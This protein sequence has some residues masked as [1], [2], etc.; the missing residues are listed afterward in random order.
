[1]H[2]RASLKSAVRD[3]PLPLRTKDASSVLAD[4]LYFIS[5]SEEHHS[6][7]P[8]PASFTSRTVGMRISSTSSEKPT[9]LVAEA[10]RSLGAMP[11]L[12]RVSRVISAFRAALTM[13]FRAAASAALNFPKSVSA[14]A[15]LTERE[16][17]HG[18][19]SS[20]TSTL[21]SSWWGASCRGV[22]TSKSSTASLSRSTNPISKSSSASSLAGAVLVEEVARVG[23]VVSSGSALVEVLDV[24]DSASVIVVEESDT[25]F[26]SVTPPLQLNR[27]WPRLIILSRTR[28]IVS[29]R[30]SFVKARWRKNFSPVFLDKR[31]RC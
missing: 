20:S 30:E 13:A 2:L 5:S 25:S 1:M 29:P 3:T 11:C 7:T 26:F 22:A 24:D 6:F 8:R 9:R 19:S 17:I 28:F 31:G 21:S 27:L 12:L 10:E 14:T 16:R 18:L 15:A 23:R 4:S